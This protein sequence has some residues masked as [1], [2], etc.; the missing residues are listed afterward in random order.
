MLRPAVAA[1]EVAARR[2][3]E[4]AVAAVARGATAGL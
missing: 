2:R 1:L 4:V 3:E